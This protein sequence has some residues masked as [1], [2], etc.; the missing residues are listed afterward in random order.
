MLYIFSVS[1]HIQHLILLNIMGQI[2]KILHTFFLLRIY[3][4]LSRIS[5]R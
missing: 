2:Y 5:Q 1:Q 4:D 3:C